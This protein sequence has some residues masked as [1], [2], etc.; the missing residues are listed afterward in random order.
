MSGINCPSTFFPTAKNRSTAQLLPLFH[1]AGLL[2]VV[3]KALYVGA[4]VH[5][6]TA[7]DPSKLMNY[8][9]NRKVGRSCRGKYKKYYC[10]YEYV[11]FVLV[12]FN[13]H[14]V[15][16]NQ[17]TN[18]VMVPSILNFMLSRP[19]FTRENFGHVESLVSGAAPVPPAT[20]DAIKSTLGDINIQHGKDIFLIL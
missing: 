6:I 15:V 19:E 13:I 7:F 12:F 5:N 2:A 16:L 8:L 17:V 11:F 20:V 10:I 9:I 18:I 3:G 1:L 14:F 4:S